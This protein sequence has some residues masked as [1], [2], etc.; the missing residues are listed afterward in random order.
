MYQKMNIGNGFMKKKDEQAKFLKRLGE[1]LQKGYSFSEAIDFLLIP[2]EK[3]AKR[4]KQKIINSLHKGESISTII[5]QQ[6]HVPDHVCAQI[7]FAEHH[8]Q[9]G[10]AL[11]EAGKYLITR[12]EN[13]QK[14]KQII[15]YPILL[16]LIS[17]LMMVLLRKILFPRFQSLYTSLGYQPSSNIQH[18]LTFIENFPVFCSVFLVFLLSTITL[19]KV[20]KSKISPVRVSLL[21]SKAPYFSKFFRIAQTHFFAREIS[22]LLNS[23]VSITE[24]LL[25]INKQTYRPT[26]QYISKKLINGLKEGKAFHECISSVT[27]FQQELSYV[28]NHGQSNGRLAEELKL[29]SDICLQELEDRSNRVIKFI[30]PLIFTVVGLFIM[31]IYF[32]IM[33][34]L[35]QMMQGI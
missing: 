8:G 28:V 25:I 35:F 32:S 12:K 26:F 17:I 24:A 18:L 6:L 34:P 10:L 9:M 13:Q 33:M 22:F 14:V 3:K 16:I 21:L 11:T 1:L 27:V 4:F 7:F 5:H 15:Q 2:E 30:Q 20:F 19:L 31:A 29:Y 23:G